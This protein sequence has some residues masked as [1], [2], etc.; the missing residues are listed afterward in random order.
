M[1]KILPNYRIDYDVW[2][3]FFYKF[4]KTSFLQSYKNVDFLLGAPYN[5]LIK[6]RYAQKRCQKYWKEKEKNEKDC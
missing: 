2:Q 6:I 5:R 1:T 3:Y 4:I